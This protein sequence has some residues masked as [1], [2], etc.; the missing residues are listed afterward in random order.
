MKIG[1]SEAWAL[2][3]TG[4]Q[5]SYIR[6]DL[7]KDFPKVRVRRPYTVGLGGKILTINEECI[8]EIEINGYSMTFK[9]SIIDE[10]FTIEGKLVGVIV[11]TAAME[12][13]EITIDVKNR[14][15]NL[16]GLKRREFT[17]LSFMHQILT[18]S[19]ASSDIFHD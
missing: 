18:R 6:R 16:E 2:F 3:D 1:G 13:W 17:E 11:G 9:A 15:L 4:S 12:E 19:Q 10:P 5:R 7:T 8:A 14:K